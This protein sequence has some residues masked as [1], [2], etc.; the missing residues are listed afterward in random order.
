MKKFYKKLVVNIN[1]KSGRNNKGRICVRRKGGGHKRLYRKIDFK[2]K[3]ND[4]NILRIEYDPNRNSLIALIFDFESDNFKYIILSE[5]L[6]KNN[7]FNKES[8]SLEKFSGASKILSDIP[9]GFFLYN[10]EVSPGQGGIFA[11]SSGTFC[12]ILNKNFDKGYASLL[13]PSGEIRLF[14]LKCNA[15][16]G[17]VCSKKKEKRKK[18]GDSRHC[19]KRPSVRGVA[20]NPVDHPHGGGEGKSSGGRPSV[21]PWGIP[22][23]G[24]RTRNKKKK[25]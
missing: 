12:K 21:T 2:F 13:M 15:S 5:D 6:Y 19:N 18:A 8:F 24:K 22:T 3:S 10:V 11:R 25:N 9:I 16:L 4:Y 1:R 23:K 20:M 14:N 7:K 17:K